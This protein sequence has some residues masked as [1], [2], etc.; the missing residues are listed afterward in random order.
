MCVK[1][2][3]KRFGRLPNWKQQHHCAVEQ[4]NMPGNESIQTY[5][6]IAV[7]FQYLEYQ[8]SKNCVQTIVPV[9]NVLLNICFCVVTTCK[10]M[11]KVHVTDNLLRFHVILKP[12]H[13]DRV[14]NFFSV[15]VENFATFHLLHLSRR[16]AYY[17]YSYEY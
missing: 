14:A 16:F 15:C 6:F 11:F 4:L 1:K 10:R 7:H 12:Y 2:Q 9:R 3:A 13:I 8:L 5:N 17:M